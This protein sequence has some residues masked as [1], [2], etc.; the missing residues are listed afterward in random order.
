MNVNGGGEGD[1]AAVDVTEGTQVG[2]TQFQLATYTAQNLVKDGTLNVNFVVADGNNISWLSF[3][4][5]KYT[6]VRDLTP[7]EEAVAPTAIALYNGETEVTEPIALDA[8]TN[9][10]TLT[11]TLTPAEATEG[12]LAWT[13]SD[14]TVATVADGV[15]TGV[16]PGTATITVTSTLDA[17][18]SATATV[19][20]SYPESEYATSSYVN[21]GATRTVVTL[22]EN[23]FKNGSFGYPNAVYGWKTVGYTTDAVT[24][25]FTINATGGANDG[26]YITTNGG[27]T[28]SEKTL[29]KSI[30]VEVGKT[31]YF[32]VYTSGKAPS[33][34]NLQYNALFAMSNATTES[35]KLKEF[36][37]PQGAGNTTT[38][39][40]KT[41][42]I[43]TATTPY[44]GVRMGWNENSNF[45]E[46]V[47]AEVISQTTEGNVDYATAA[48]PTANIGT[49]A[50]QYSQT[51][52]N[53]ANALVQGTA[54]VAEVEAAYEALQTLN[55]PAANKVY[56]VINITSGYAYNGNA[57]TFLS[58]S[59]ADLTGN[60]TNMKWYAT[61]G[62]IY[63]Q[64][65]TF[66][67]VEGVTNGYKMSYTRADGSVVYVATGSSSGLGSNT[68]QIRPTTDA[69]KAL[70]VVVTYT[71][72]NKWS[73]LNT[74]DNHSIGATSDNGFYT[75]GGANKDVQIQEAVNNEVSLS[76]TAANKYGTLI[77]P[78]EA[79]VPAGVTAYSV[80]EV[81]GSTLTLNDVESFAANTPYIVYAEVGATETLA[82][83]GAAY[84]DA[85][86]TSGL[87]TGVYTATSE[88]PDDSYVLAS[89]N[90]KVAFYQVDN[91]DKPTVGAN[92][93]YLTAPATGGGESPAKARAF[94]FDDDTATA[95]ATISALT[96][97]EVEAIYTIGGARVNSLQKGIN[98]V[99]MKNGETKKIIVK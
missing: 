49:G 10:T 39:W 37:W 68:A 41:E 18:V 99:K 73:L 44:V 65:V 93:A 86:Y 45:D 15:V 75:N 56:N 60:T 89:I 26:A 67:A 11:A 19:T 40:S 2:E 91:T 34:N 64:G 51:A 94:Y 24:N 83:L 12:N 16:A 85:T 82:G 80:E 70:T 27:G 50:F 96:S 31:Y 97:G 57:L 6:K 36:E 13:S 35:A 88:I 66:T 79:T 14:E 21:D 52:I 47:L 22:G 29:R 8:T 54:T 42:Y 81:S 92:R 30:A 23:L 46:F 53:A 7:E 95:I 74:E 77:L 4:N 84:T 9:T 71:G 33:S 76:I 87:L 78:F 28:G 43:F 69:N 5:V 72:D 63:P 38:E 98:I 62:S 25:N 59:D 17:E 55:A 32:S 58:A 90:N 48:I 1:Y 61:P 20:V 3:K